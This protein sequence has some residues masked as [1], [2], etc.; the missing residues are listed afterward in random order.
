MA[1]PAQNLLR[2]DADRL[3]ADAG[4]GD[5]L[6]SFVHAA[7]SANPSEWEEALMRCRSGLRDRGRR[8]ALLGAG[9]L[10]RICSEGAGPS[11][12]TSVVAQ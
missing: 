6:R 7:A 12:I 3:A 11:A 4:V 8:R 10:A 1:Q 5:D 2:T 9:R